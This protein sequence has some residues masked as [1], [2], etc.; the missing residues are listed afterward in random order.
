MNSSLSE[1]QITSIT[2]VEVISPTATDKQAPQF[3]PISQSGTFR[4]PSSTINDKNEPNHDGTI[5]IDHGLDSSSGQDVVILPQTESK[6][7][8]DIKVEPLESKPKIEKDDWT[9]VSDDEADSGPEII[10]MIDSKDD[11]DGDGFHLSNDVNREYIKD[12]PFHL[13]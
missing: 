5:V 4:F 3:V 13:K 9:T 2:P 10:D 11:S 8:Q 12:L 7:L 6:N 1:S